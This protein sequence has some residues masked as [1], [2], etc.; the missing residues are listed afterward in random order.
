MANRRTYQ[1]RGAL[2]PV[3]KELFARI[4]FAGTGAPTLVTSI[5]LA[6]S[7]TVNPSLG[8]AGIIR[9]SAGNYTITLQDKYVYLLNASC[10]FV[11]PSA[12]PAAP[13]MYLTS[14]LV[15]TG[16]TVIVQFL[17]PDGTTATDPASGEEVR[18]QLVL[19]DST[20]P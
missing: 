17:A 6:N 14:S 9:N 11:D 18:I 2:V 10:V 15:N 19:C 12:A 20:A 1:F 13:D 16:P 3:V 8:I 7:Q 4:T 5:T